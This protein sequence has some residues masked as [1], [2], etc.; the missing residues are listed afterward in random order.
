MEWFRQAKDSQGSVATKSL[1]QAKVANR[2]GCYIVGTI[3]EECQRFINEE[4]TLEEVIELR[5]SE[6]NKD[7]G[8]DEKSYSLTEIHDLQSRLMLLG[9]DKLTTGTNTAEN[10]QIEKDYFV[11]V[12][13][14]IFSATLILL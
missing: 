5:T 1:M 14:F 9:I 12:P 8:K 7:G 3:R 6:Q 4:A 13:L 10:K 2:N 11:Q